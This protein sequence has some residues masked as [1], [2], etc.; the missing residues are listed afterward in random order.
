MEHGLTYLAGT[1]AVVA[2]ATLAASY[3]MVRASSRSALW[4]IWAGAM[5]VALGAVLLLI[6]AIILIRRA[7]PGR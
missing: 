1:L 4:N 6:T 5:A 2:L 3:L 7:F